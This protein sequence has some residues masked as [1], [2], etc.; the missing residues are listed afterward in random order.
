MDSG[1]IV[2]FTVAGIGGSASSLL[3]LA[4]TL[5]R[6]EPWSFGAGYFGGVFLFFAFGCFLAWI[7]E[8]NDRR[9]ALFV[10]LSMP[11]FFATAQTQITARDLAQDLAPPGWVGGGSPPQTSFSRIFPSVHARTG[12]AISQQ[13]TPGEPPPGTASDSRPDILK[14]RLLRECPACVVVWTVNGEKHHR[15]VEELRS[16]DDTVFLEVTP[17]SIQFGIW[18]TEI[19]P[20]MW[21]LP[22]DGPRVYEFDYEGNLWNDFRRGIGN[23]NIRPYDAIVTADNGAHD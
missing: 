2:I 8:E 19:N 6:G 16:E 12:S 13:D 9:R 15:L 23:Y 14:I 7:F 5:T 17:G 11:A 4:T 21:T 1:R 22:F 20:R 18:N 10:G 3:D